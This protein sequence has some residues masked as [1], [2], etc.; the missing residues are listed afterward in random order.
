[1]LLVLLV[2]VLLVVVMMLMPLLLPEVDKDVVAT[3]DSRGVCLPAPCTAPVA[4][5]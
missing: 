3:C 5:R 4:S 1:L 2:M